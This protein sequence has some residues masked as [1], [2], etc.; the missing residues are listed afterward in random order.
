MDF[1]EAGLW[2]TGIEGPHSGLPSV[3]IAAVTEQSSMSRLFGIGACLVWEGA[4]G[5]QTAFANL[6]TKANK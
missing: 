3:V 5:P 6:P 2:D 4:P 1:W